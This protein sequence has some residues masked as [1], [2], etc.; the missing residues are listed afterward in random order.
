[1]KITEILSESNGKLSLWRITQ[2][3]VLICFVIDWMVNLFGQGV[4]LP[5][6]EKVS[7]LTSILVGKVIQK[8]FENGNNNKGDSEEG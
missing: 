3:I 8:K 6:W 1:M 2:L 7:I 4:Y 5:T